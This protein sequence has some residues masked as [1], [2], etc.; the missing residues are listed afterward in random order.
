MLLLI[1]TALGTLLPTLL[2]SVGVNASID[3]LVTAAATAIAAIVAGIQNKAPVDA[4]LVVLETAIVALEEN[5]SI[6][7]QIL[8]DCAEGLRVT[9][10][11]VAAYRQSLITTDP[12]LLTPLP[13]VE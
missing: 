9:K 1:L 10:A 8:D 6:D 4:S 13:E 5:T 3:N 12:S 7:P 2:K 11:A